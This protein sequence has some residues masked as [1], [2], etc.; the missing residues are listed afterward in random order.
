[1]ILQVFSNVYYSMWVRKIVEIASSSALPQWKTTTTKRRNPPETHLCLFTL[2]AVTDNSIQQCRC[3]GWEPFWFPRQVTHR[4]QV[5]KQHLPPSSIWGVAN[6]CIEDHLK[7]EHGK[8][9]V[10]KHTTT[11]AKGLLGTESCCSPVRSRVITRFSCQ[12]SNKLTKYLLQSCL[13]RNFRMSKLFS[14]L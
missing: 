3:W 2:T 10:F 5:P 8:P 14:N 12:P 7:V 6:V 4:K 1:M 11:T 9:G 13:Y